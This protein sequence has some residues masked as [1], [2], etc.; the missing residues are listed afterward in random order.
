MTKIQEWKLQEWKL[1]YTQPASR[2]EEALP[3]G[4]GRIGG[5]VYGGAVSETISLNEDTLWSGFPRDNANY[6]AIRYLGQA[7]E[8]IFSGKYK[9]A[10]SLIDQKMLGRRTESYLPVGDLHLVHLGAEE[11][12]EIQDY[13]RD[14]DLDT[15]IA[16]T[17]YRIGGAVFKREV[18]VSAAD[19]VLV[20]HLETEGPQPFG[21]KVTL[22]SPLQYRT[23]D[24]ANGH[25]VMTG[26]APSHVADNYLGNH[27]QSVL[28]EDGLGL[29]FEVRVQAILD[30][31]TAA[32][33]PDGVLQIAGA[34]KV[35]LLLAA[36]TNFS[37]F[38]QQP[39]ANPD[40]ELR[41]S[42][43]LRAA[44]Q[45]GIQQLKQ[46]HLEDHR[47]LFRRVSLDLGSSSEGEKLPTDERLVRYR[48][49]ESDPQ[50]EALYFQY[51]R[52][53]LM[54]S[55]RPGT[56]PANLQG[57]WNPHVQPPWNSNY[58]TN[59]N[60]EMNYWHA[61]VCNLSE[62][63]E[64]LFDLIQ[65]LSVTG[66][67]TARIHY[68]ARG[69][70]AHHNV[71]LWRSSGPSDGEASWA[72]WPMSGI[73]LCRH[74]WEHYLF[75]PDE[76]YLRTTA[77]PLLKGAALFALDWLVEG[78][79]G[80]LTTAPSTSPENKFLTPDGEPCS[81]SAGTA[82]DMSMIAELFEICQQAAAVLEA[83]ED[84]LEE[85]RQAA[86]RLALPGIAPDGRLREWSVDFPESEPGHRHVSHLYGLYPGESITPEDTPELAAAARKSLDS[87][88]AQ[89]GGHT[90]WSCAWLINLHARLQDGEKAYSFVRTLLSRSTYPNLFDEHPP[91]QI[92]GNFGGSAG[93]A[94]MLLQ[95][96]GGT[97]HLLPALPADWQE[98]S[99]SGL[100]ARGG[101]T[102]DL[103][104]SGGKLAKAEIQASRSGV[105]R[106]RYREGVTV[107]V[108][109]EAGD[110]VELLNTEFT[111]S[112]ASDRGVSGNSSAT[113]AVTEIVFE[114]QAGRTYHIVPAAN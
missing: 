99:I 38:A 70:T 62:C 101:Y 63:H 46:R 114:V 24:G 3:V 74:L 106:L 83:D 77:L 104:W 108:S 20:V 25:L 56:Q 53:L 41:N 19:Q 102:V 42:E 14:L 103:Q 51:G 54:G 87:R 43:T 47:R 91:F 61:E 78:P 50:L 105:C 89:G 10:E 71:D 60:T 16:Q 48:N 2:W 65:D 12:P 8:L 18:F 1:Q 80:R 44:A 73:W 29:A 113:G 45:L 22:D 95:S 58:T 72:F 88:V 111:V 93:I 6:E 67:R 69:W 31:G 97:I 15:G 90:G 109:A 23:H 85:V 92:D 35:T 57:I 9:Q 79:D 26:Q 66:A 64:P 13:W 86:G 27:P 39:G 94:E 68:G 84:W 110:G 107:K 5:M 21:L 100:R 4:N 11:G 75:Q 28:Y 76:D 34:N 82:M 112:I 36:E 52:Y 96:H 7:R 30:S 32:V 17:T 59:I 37:G 55:S 33:Q 49:G 98:G 81:V 40:W